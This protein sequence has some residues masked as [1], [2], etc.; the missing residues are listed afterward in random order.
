MIELTPFLKKLLIQAGLSAFETPVREVIADAWRPLV[1]ELTVSRVGSLH[2]LRYGAAPSPQGDGAAAMD[3]RPRILLSAHMDAI[4]LMV[5][6]STDGL[7]RFTEV[8]GVDPRILPGQVVTVHG[9]TDL[10][11]VVVQPIDRLLPPAARGK[12][13]AIEYLFIDTGLPAEEVAQQVRVGDLAS[14]AQLPLEL[15]DETLAGHSLDNR[16]SVAA[17]TLCLDELQNVRHAWDVWAVASSQEEESFAGAYTSPFEIQPD[18]AVAIDV[19]F[20]KGPGVNDFRGY[21]LGKGPTLG[22]GPNIH[23]ALYKA[24][25]DLADKL[26]IPHAME[27][28]PRHSGTDAFAMQV[29]AEG[30]P[31]MVISIPLRYMHTP[32]ELV[33]L[34]DISRT[35]HLLAEFI[36]RLKPDFIQKIHWDE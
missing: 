1:D 21:P 2:G 17:V 25:S 14:F 27:A 13:V 6:G 4:G 15:T 10:P 32:V 19:T 3:R 29:V 26:D 28:M 23:P 11:G 20:A 9:R 33:A 8:G 36:A 31:T 34:K 7:L 16:A 12:P 18:L 24:F 5:T 22:W 35:G 30:I